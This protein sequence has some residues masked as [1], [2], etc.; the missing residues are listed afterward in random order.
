M[1]SEQRHAY[2]REK[3][4]TILKFFTVGNLRDLKVL[5]WQT[6]AKQRVP[7]AAEIPSGFT[8]VNKSVLFPRKEEAK[9]TDP[10]ITMSNAIKTI[11]T[12]AKMEN[13]ASA[14]MFRTED[15]GNMI[16]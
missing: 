12:R 2:P 9:S 13:L 14:E 16:K 7:I 5:W 15:T 11:A 1:K 10:S 4:L 3:K 6:Y 8:K